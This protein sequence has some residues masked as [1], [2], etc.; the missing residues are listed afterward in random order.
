MSVFKVTITKVVTNGPYAYVITQDGVGQKAAV[1]QAT[2][3]VALDGVKTDIGT[4]LGAQ[5]VNR[6][7]MDITSS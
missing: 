4:L 1:S 6:V 7:G 3:S 2:I 5:T